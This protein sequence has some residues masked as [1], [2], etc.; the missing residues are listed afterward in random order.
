MQIGETKKVFSKPK[1]A[2]EQPKLLVPYE[3]IFNS[4]LKCHKAIGH[5]G[6]DLTMHECSRGHLNLARYLISR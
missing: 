4:I 6:R 2:G 3:D 5:K 1:K